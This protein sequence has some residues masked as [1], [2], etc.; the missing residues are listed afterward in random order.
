MVFNTVW[1]FCRDYMETNMELWKL[2]LIWTVAVAVV[3]GF[4]F[5]LE[6]WWA[7]IFLAGFYSIGVGAFVWD[8][9]H[10]QSPQKCRDFLR[11]KRV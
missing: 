5:W 9:L 3:T 2:L 4:L 6:F 10:D 8:G 11:A 1:V 7:G